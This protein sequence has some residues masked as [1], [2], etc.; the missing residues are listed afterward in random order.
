[1]TALYWAGTELKRSVHKERGD[2]LEI[3]YNCTDCK[4]SVSLSCLNFSNEHVNS[5]VISIT[6]P[7]PQQQNLMNESRLLNSQFLTHTYNPSDR[8]RVPQLQDVVIFVPSTDK[9]IKYTCFNSIPRRRWGF[10][11][12]PSL[13]LAAAATVA[14]HS[15][16]RSACSRT[17]SPAP[18]TPARSGLSANL[19]NPMPRQTAVR[20]RYRLSS[21]LK[22]C[23]KRVKAVV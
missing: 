21:L 17:C 10:A 18:S 13:M 16:A 23:C 7:S 2:S 5:W 8:P 14:S 20:E 12:L 22:A 4:L 9:T 6:Q 1:M 19:P 15:T 11:Y 3:P